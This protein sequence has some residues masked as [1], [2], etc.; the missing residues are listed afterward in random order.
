MLGPEV[1][2]APAG[3]GRLA[4]WAL[5]KAGCVRV[6]QYRPSTVLHVNL[7]RAIYEL[8]GL[9]TVLLPEVLW[10]GEKFV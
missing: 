1:L 5:L 10:W 4:E 7:V 3:H 2:L 8:L 9:V 6:V